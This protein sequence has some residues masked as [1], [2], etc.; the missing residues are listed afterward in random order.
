MNKAPHDAVITQIAPNRVTS[1]NIVI[2]IL[3]PGAMGSAISMRLVE[4]GARV[5]T[6]LDGRSAATADRA[7]AAGFVPTLEI[8]SFIFF[9]N[10][11]WTVICSV[12]E[13][14]PNRVLRVERGDGSRIVLVD[15]RIIFYSQ[16]TNLLIYFWI[17][18]RNV[19]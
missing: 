6:S 15:R 7:R 8:E 2:A 5:L 13:R 3:S 17:A 1:M 19:D 11:S 10:G 12:V 16:H 14:R 9:F 4:H 18:A